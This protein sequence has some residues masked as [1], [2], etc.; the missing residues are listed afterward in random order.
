MTP[1]KGL[2]PAIKPFQRAQSPGIL[3]T[4]SEENKL[5][6]IKQNTKSTKSIFHGRSG[7]TIIIADPQKLPKY[8][9]K[10]ER[11]QQ[12]PKKKQDTSR[13][14]LYDCLILPNNKFSHAFLIPRKTVFENVF[15]GIRQ[16][17][18]KKHGI[19]GL[20][21]GTAKIHMATCLN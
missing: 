8:H 21:S 12:K 4:T 9:R 7:Q 3:R 13:N 20:P 17:M 19:N 1:L 5:I 10:S 16:T 18:K 11:R 6:S 15:L 14:N 2:D